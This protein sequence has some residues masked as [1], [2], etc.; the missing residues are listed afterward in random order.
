LMHLALTGL[1]RAKFILR[2]LDMAEGMVADAARTNI[3]KRWN[4]RA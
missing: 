1:F 3:W 4:A 2:L